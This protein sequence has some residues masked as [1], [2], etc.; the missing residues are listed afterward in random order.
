MSHKPVRRAQLIS[1]FGVGA[2]IDFPNDEALMTAGL[3]AWPYAF[4]SCPSDWR[5][6]EERLQERLGVD[7]FR[8]PPD[9]RDDEDSRYRFQQI[10]FVRFPRW[11]Y[12]PSASC[13]KMV[14]RNLF[15]A[16]TPS[17][18][19]EAHAGLPKYRQ[20]RPIPVRFVSICP[21]GHIEDF[22]FMEWVHAGSTPDNVSAHILSYRAGKSAALTG[23]RISCSCGKSRSMGGAFSFDKDSGGA[24]S[25]IGHLCSGNQ[26][27]LGVTDGNGPDC[28]DHL[29]VVQRGGANVYFPRTYSSIYLPLWG[30]E[31][32]KKIVQTLEEP[33]VWDI[34]TSGLEE[35]TK[36]SPE[37]CETVASMRGVDSRKL[38]EAAQRRLDGDRIPVDATEEDFRRSEYEALRNARGDQ[39]TDLFVEKAEIGDYSSWVSEIFDKI[40]LVRKLR[41]TRV[42]ES[43]SRL[44]PV[45]SDNGPSADGVQPL[46]VRSVINW[47]PAMIVRGEGIFFEL[48][49]ERINDWI[50]EGKA[51]VRAKKLSAQYN[52]S[53]LQRGL[54]NIEVD[55][56][57]LLMH[58][59][60][61]SLI[62]QLSYDC[63]YGSAA[64]R[65]R[66]YCNRSQGSDTM[67]GIL[68]YTAAG[69]S[70]GTMGGLVRQ[71][72][73]GNLEPSIMAAINSAVW[74]SS[75]PVCIESEGQGTDSA[76]LAACHSCGLLPETSCEEG[77]R[78]LDRAMICGT[79]EDP[80]IG[81]L[82]KFSQK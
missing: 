67:H 57:F 60:A 2:M 55:A 69:D 53:R 3:E 39:V 33:K 1:P 79:P 27:W 32:D 28:G 76:N 36:I 77:N 41:E 44:L 4:E 80:D 65:E 5:I 30:E 81:F 70:E 61:H 24:L 21:K 9:Y 75:D 14:K 11:H 63:G 71:G 31:T 74:C 52:Q 37:K 10:P 62:R 8:L 64:L 25:R 22:P 78:L 40:C 6:N 59:L 72:A 48:N 43:F 17:C 47:L 50:G 66:I 13:G 16:G 49:E 42:L 12:C 23:I 7:H 29:R 20:P 46:S 54:T 15:G 26:P 68:I 45:D 58:T 51:D 35:G 38:L 19:S 34:L 56:K 73:S 82:S 18:D